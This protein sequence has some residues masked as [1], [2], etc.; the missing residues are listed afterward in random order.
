[1]LPLLVLIEDLIR[2]SVMLQL[3]K[4]DPTWHEL[5][6]NLPTNLPCNPLIRV[7][8]APPGGGPFA[9]GWARGMGLPT[10]LSCCPLIRV[11]T[12]GHHRTAGLLQWEVRSND[13]EGWPLFGFTRCLPSPLPA[14]R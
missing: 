6:M 13:I 1:M 7:G 14:S 10:N 4:P 11:L 9:V 2:A 3:G 8:R 12:G 5:I